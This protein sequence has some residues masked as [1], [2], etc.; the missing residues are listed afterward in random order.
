MPAAVELLTILQSHETCACAS[1]IFSAPRRASPALSRNLRTFSTFSSIPPSAF[2]LSMRSIEEQI[3][4]SIGSPSNYEE[5]LDRARDAARQ[6]RFITGARLL[7][8]IISPAQAGEAYAAIATA[9]LRVSYE[10]VRK[11][12]EADHGVVPGAQVAS[13]ASAVSARANSRQGR[14]STSSSS[15]ISMKRRAR[16]PA[17]AL[18]TSWS[19]TRA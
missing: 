7:S 1:P 6:M 3:R 2:R 9:I 18:S 14:I 11:G 13:S 5:F 19:I 4:Q 12:F 8:D 16:A 15:T 10:Q 17:P